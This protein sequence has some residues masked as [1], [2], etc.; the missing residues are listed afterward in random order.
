MP[1]VCGKLSRKRDTPR[2][3]GIPGLLDLDWIVFLLRC[4]YSVLFEVLGVF[5]GYIVFIGAD[6]ITSV[7]HN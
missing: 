1:G 3:I 4:F 6:M 7:K 2:S 5:G